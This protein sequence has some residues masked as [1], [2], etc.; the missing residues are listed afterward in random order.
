MQMAHPR[1][2]QILFVLL[3]AE[4]M[5]LLD[6]TVVNV[7]AP[8]IHRDLGTSSTALQWIIGG[9]P[10]AIAIGLVTG[11]RLGDL[12]GRKRMFV[13]GAVGFTIASVLCGVAP[14]TGT[15]IAAR[16]VQGGFG[17]LMLPQGLGILRDVFPREE[18]T[19][20]YA[21]FGPVMGSAALLGPIISGG[22]ID[23]SLFSTGW[24]SV[25]LINLPV[26]AAAVM[27]A[28]RLIPSDRER[29]GG[30]L[31]LVGTALVG[32]GAGLFVYPLIQGRELGWP[33]WTYVCI[34]AGVA[35]FALLAL[36]L[37][38]R[39]R[40][41]K[42]PLVRPSMFAHR[43][44]SGG[45]AVLV[46]YFGGMI[47]GSLAI[48]LFMQ[49]GEHFSAIHAGL[50]MIPFPLGVAFTAPVG[51]QL[52]RRYG[53]L[54]IQVGVVVSAAGYVL[55]IPAVV[56][57]HTSTWNLVG[58]LFVMGIGMG[59]FIGPVFG[60]IVNAVSNRETGSASGVMNAVQQLAG[61]TGVAVLG[62][63][64]F[65]VA[66]HGDFVGALQRVMWWELGLLA[67][68]L[69]ASTLLPKTSLGE[70]E[71]VMA[72]IAEEPQPLAA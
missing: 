45:L 59:L 15:L 63:V 1:R 32:L 65:T 43:G 6:G 41:G 7:A 51:A 48:T 29:R 5:D 58:P 49:I 2:W 17:A 71:L 67:L 50:T 60:T 35:V 66:S 26:G 42:E 30:S 68:V 4:C 56:G 18:M 70:E 16:L 14:S 34:G 52:G 25:F 10:L 36:H 19:K 53:R 24:R 8:T 23:L 27:G 47:G 11:G 46:L 31:D 21:V 12:L 20:A 39:Q 61:A 54:L 40:A 33:T 62:T 69:L 13:L 28:L 22:L 37:V 38:R 44:Y 57:A 64:F 72:Q 55:V 3:A 9:Y